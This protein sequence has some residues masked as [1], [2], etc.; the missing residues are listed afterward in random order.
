M[1]IGIVVYSQTGN[2][3]SVS[4]KLKEKLTAAGH[5]VAVER[6]VAE[7]NVHPGMK[8][9]QLKAKPEVGAYDALV[10]G[11]PVQGFGL[12]PAMVGYL[13]QIGSLKGRKVACMVTQGLPF[14]GMGANQAITRMKELCESKDGAVCGAGS[15]SWMRAPREKNIAALV[16]RMSALF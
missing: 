13:E 8:N 2:T 15:V 12:S 5:A 7:G 9:L 11:A 3:H 14:P 10:F 16:D 1:K 6:I 4:L